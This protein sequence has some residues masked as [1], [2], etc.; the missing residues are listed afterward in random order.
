M[1]ITRKVILIKLYRDYICT[2]IGLSERVVVRTRNHKAVMYF[3][4]PFIANFI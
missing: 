3:R 2:G 4:L 1:L